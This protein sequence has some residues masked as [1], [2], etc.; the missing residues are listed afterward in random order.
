MIEVFN[1]FD[2]ALFHI[3]YLYAMHGGKDYFKVEIYRT[4]D[5][6]FRVGIITE[7]QLEMDI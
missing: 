4:D 6:R 7:Q 2:D 5:G 3:D 1:T